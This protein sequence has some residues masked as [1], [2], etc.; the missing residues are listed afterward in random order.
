MNRRR[1]AAL[2]EF[3]IGLPFALMLFIGISDF[4]G[5][6]WQQV[7][8]EEVARWVHGRM[9]P[10]LDGYARADR[11]T[12]ARLALDLQAEAQKDLAMSDLRV[13]LSRHYACPLPTGGE[14]KLTDAAQLCDGER[15][16]LRVVSDRDV[17]PL[18]APLRQLGYPRT[19][20][21]RHFLRIR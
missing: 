6:F 9:A 5:Y 20:F 8:M 16:Y 11:E 2:I 14:K 4:T 18:F 21:S 19:S 7:R 15:V 3:A 17:A 10:T 12:M 13:T 1:G